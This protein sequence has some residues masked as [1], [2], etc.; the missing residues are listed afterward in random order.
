MTKIYLQLGSNQGESL[1][2][3]EEA[4][5]RISHE[6]G[7]ITAASSIYESEAWGLKN[8]NN[9]LNQVIEVQTTKTPL[10]VL[11]ASQNI[12]NTLGRKRVEHWGP[13]TMDIDLLF[14]ENQ[15]IDHAPELIIPHPRINQR[16]FVLEPLNE[17][18]AEF[19]H[20]ISKRSISQLLYLCEDSG[21]VWKI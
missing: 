21:K 1:K 11:K 14:F 3:I 17:I 7:L 10:E 12:E 8:Q 18:A 5:N 16:K 6:I 2:L 19:I 4:H 20:P 15:I 9:F 13:R